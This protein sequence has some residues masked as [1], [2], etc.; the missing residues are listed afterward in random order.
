MRADRAPA[1]GWTRAALSGGVLAGVWLAAAPA[2]AAC[3]DPA[4]PGVDWQRCYFEERNLSEANLTGANLRDARFHR[5]NLTGAVLADVDAFH[6]KF[7]TAK[8]RR[9]TFDGARLTEVDF[10][11]ADLTDASLKNA[12]LRRARL[13]RTI[14][15]GADLTG[16]QLRGADLTRADLSGALWINGTTICAEGSI[17]QCKAQAASGGRAQAGSAGGT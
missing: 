5:S 17:G 15:R 16:A 3:T 11:K 6:A 7:N 10:S 13:F 4:A 1:K 2:M 12:D 8:L 14:L 9:A